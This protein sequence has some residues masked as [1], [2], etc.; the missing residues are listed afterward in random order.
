MP[1][2]FFDIRFYKEYINNIQNLDELSKKYNIGKEALRL[3]LGKDGKKIDRLLTKNRVLYSPEYTF[4]GLE[5]TE[6]DKE[7]L[8]ELTGKDFTDLKWVKN[9]LPIVHKSIEFLERMNEVNNTLFVPVHNIF[10]AH[11]K[12]IKKDKLTSM[13]N[14]IPIINKIEKE[15]LYSDTL[16]KAILHSPE[17]NELI[18]GGF[19]I[20]PKDRDYLI[21]FIKKRSRIEPTLRP[22]IPLGLKSPH[23]ILDLRDLDASVRLY[24]ALA[25]ER[26]TLVRD[27]FLFTFSDIQ[28]FRGIGKYTI[29]ELDLLLNSIGT[30]LSQLYPHEITDYD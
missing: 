16:L 24:N 20:I 7:L 13:E 26:I 8:S 14:L 3:R 29:R 12:D 15:N 22:V 9:N 19:K 11:V 5:V 2:D 23:Y 25:L 6:A 21:R 17:F 4:R 30:S 28:S 27:L 1:K 10:N 18:E